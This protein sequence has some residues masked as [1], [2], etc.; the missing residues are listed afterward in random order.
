METLNTNKAII[1]I[2]ILASSTSL[3]SGGLSFT[4]IT[5]S[6]GVQGA[7]GLQSGEHGIAWGDIKNTRDR[8]YFFSVDIERMVM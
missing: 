7:G 4:D 2:S 5:F 6:A 8:P 3:L 1:I